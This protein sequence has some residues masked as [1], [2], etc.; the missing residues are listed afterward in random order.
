MKMYIYLVE[1]KKNKNKYLMIG[2]LKDCNMGSG[3]YLYNFVSSD[4]K[5]TRKTPYGS[6]SN[7]TNGLKYN[8]KSYRVLHQTA[9]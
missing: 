6:R 4:Y 8:S 2:N 1:N 7:I 9:M 5:C 3:R